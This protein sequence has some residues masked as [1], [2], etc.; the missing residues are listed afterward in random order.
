MA[1]IANTAKS[2]TVWFNILMGGV[3]ALHGMLQMT[4]SIL[5]PDVFVYVSL[6][7]GMTHAMGGV[8]L[9]TITTTSLDE[10]Q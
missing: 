5:S 6:A 10:K 7:I 3:E 8:Y 9:R 1:T 2:K 4:E